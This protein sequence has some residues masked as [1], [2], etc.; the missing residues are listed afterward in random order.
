MAALKR[1]DLFINQHMATWAG[2]M[3]FNWFKTGWLDHHGYFVN[4][5]TTSVR[6][7]PIDPDAWMRMGYF[8]G[9]PAEFKKIKRVLKRRNKSFYSRNWV[10]LSC[11]HKTFS[12][13]VVKGRCPECQRI[14]YMKELGRNT[15]SKPLAQTIGGLEP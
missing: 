2:D 15:K 9:I 13:G 5:E 10:L 6:K 14:N 1:Q 3:L 11:G 8:G 7:M 4:L 12:S